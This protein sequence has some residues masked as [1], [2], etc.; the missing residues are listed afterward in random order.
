VV[1]A[2]V[3]TASVVAAS[4]VTTSAVVLSAESFSP[5]ESIAKHIRT[6]S[7]RTKIFFMVFLLKY[8]ILAVLNRNAMIISHF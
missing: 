2:S 1:T 4:V 5:Q 8:N 7:I 3:V 6:A